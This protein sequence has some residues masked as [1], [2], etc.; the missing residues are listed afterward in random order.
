MTLAQKE[1][2][3]N[4]I[5]EKLGPVQS[6]LKALATL[7]KEIESAN[8]LFLEGT[9]QIASGDPEQ[10]A[11]LQEK[12][13]ERFENIADCFTEIPAL[14]RYKEF[15]GDYPVHIQSLDS[16]IYPNYIYQYAAA[17]SG[18]V[19][20]SSL[21]DPNTAELFI[22]L[23]NASN[24]LGTL[25]YGNELE[26]KGNKDKIEKKEEVFEQ[27]KKG[28]KQEQK[29]INEL[30]KRIDPEFDV[31]V[32]K[33]GA[34]G[35]PGLIQFKSTEYPSEKYGTSGT[36]SNPL[37]VLES[38]YLVALSKYDGMPRQD[39]EPRQGLSDVVPTRK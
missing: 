2:T 38:M 15:H 11:A 24:H 20:M 35:G 32:S 9:R 14:G 36:F 22:A 21:T 3:H 18:M 37:Y 33:F 29:R 10:G 7:H 16:K 39:P 30:A 8:K 26:T 5:K 13:R 1:K 31:D 23:W 12:A 25:T 6:P 17:M 28:L 27:A 34:L 19:N 4:P